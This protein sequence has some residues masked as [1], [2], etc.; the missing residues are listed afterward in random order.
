MVIKKQESG[1]NTSKCKLRFI[2]RVRYLPYSELD[3]SLRNLG[4]QIMKYKE[5]GEKS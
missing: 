4:G 3:F 1:E 5:H 2:D